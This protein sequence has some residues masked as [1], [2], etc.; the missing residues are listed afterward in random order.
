MEAVEIVTHLSGYLE[1][2]LGNEIKDLQAMSAIE[3]IEFFLRSQGGGISLILYSVLSL[4]AFLSFAKTDLC[5]GI[6]AAFVR[7]WTWRP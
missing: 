2:R 7:A 1:D 6:T 3:D 5:A 4:F